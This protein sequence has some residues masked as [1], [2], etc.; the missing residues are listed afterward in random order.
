MIEILPI[1][2][3]TENIIFP[4]VETDVDVSVDFEKKGFDFVMSND[5]EIVALSLKKDKNS[6][7]TFSD[8][9]SVGTTG[10]ITGFLSE[11]KT[12][13]FLAN[14]IGT[15]RFE[16][17][18]IFERSGIYFAEGIKIG[19][20]HVSGD[21]KS[22][23]LVNN[24]INI[25]KQ[26]PKMAKELTFVK[27]LEKASKNADNPELFSS[28]LSYALKIPLEEKQ[29]LL[30]TLN[31]YF[32]LKKLE[33]QLRGFEAK[34]DI[35]KDI[36]LQTRKNIE[37]NQKKYYLHEKLKVIKEELGETSENEFEILKEK[38]EQTGL[39]EEAYKKAMEE[40]NRLKAMSSASAEATV[41]RTYL[42]WLL[43]IP[44]K[45]KT[46]DKLNILKAKEILDRDHYGLEDCKERIMEFLAVKKLTKKHKNP[47]ICLVGPPGVGKTSIAKGI[48]EATGRKFA[49]M[50]LG[51]VR[52]EAEI[53]G[54]RRTYIGAI[55]GRIVYMMK[56]TGTTNPL[57]LLDEIDKLSSD[58]RGD[59]SSALLEMLDP[60]Q[61]KNF[62]DHYIDVDYD[63]S[64]VFFIV[65]ANVIDTIPGALR[66]RL[67]I[68]RIPGYTFNEKKE[69]AI[70]HLI[71][72]KLYETGLNKYKINI[73]DEAIE[74]IIEKYTREAGV[75][76]LERKLEQVFRKIAVD[77]TSSSSSK[78]TIKVD[79]KT[80]LEKLSTP[81][82][83]NQL[84]E[85]KP[86]VGVA[87]GLAWT[88][89]GGDILFIEVLK[90]KGSEKIEITGQ[91]GDVM[92]ESAKAA[93]SYIKANS[94]R[95]G[96]E[97]DL[98]NK[99]DL[100]IHIPEGAI[101]K[102]GPS[103][104]ITIAAAVFSA[105]TGKTLSN[106]IAMTGEITLRGRVLPVGGIKEKLLAAHR[107]GIMEIILPE[108]NEK[109]LKDIPD[110][111]KRDMNFNL[112]D[113]MDQ[114][115]EILFNKN[116]ILTTNIEKD[117]ENF[118]FLN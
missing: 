111:I 71:P 60:E 116:K 72:K 81:P 78:K 29:E 101:P 86:M 6:R 23:K 65:T 87:A 22:L 51:G 1:I 98:I 109:D 20:S 88:P 39:S 73:E 69:I 52:D 2:S 7:I 8:F 53:R 37:E 89:V 70:R 57:L 103:A 13:D 96:L 56:K 36:E 43:D 77:I 9:Y 15:S 112:I 41:A 31:P 95:F 34:Y 10:R 76:N 18:S 11:K 102:D 114:V 93:Y 90:T 83:K 16:V 99:F 84:A 45:K 75:R 21:I 12:G 94:E 61:N 47:V 118:N 54:H 74:F 79:T 25:F 50:S 38:I 46:K 17:H 100:H 3:P 26:H 104:G 32:R 28:L 82:F 55:P 67:E 33:S 105:L 30:E 24:I 113:N 115:M 4:G 92:K 44:W 117:S 35:D 68:I 58:F 40:L 80:I 64:N 110:E 91:I 107:A 85:T 59:P 42:Q 19:E 49:R 14:I 66:D 106:K 97:N 5:S 62:V 27:Y 63:L 108:E 48:A